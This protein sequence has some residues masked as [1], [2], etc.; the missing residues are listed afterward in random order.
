MG[1][2]WS[3]S[4]NPRIL[5]PADFNT[6]FSVTGTPG[7]DNYILTSLIEASVPPGLAGDFND[8]GAVDAADYVVWRKSDGTPAGYNEWRS[9]FGRT[10]GSGSALGAA[11]VPEPSTVLLVAAAVAGFGCTRRRQA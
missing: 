7:S 9:N 3:D 11:G 8:D 6:F 4:N 1:E 2:A 10:A 5:Q